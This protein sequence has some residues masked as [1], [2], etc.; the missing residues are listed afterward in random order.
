M[1][2]ENVIIKK[3][4][5]NFIR[6]SFWDGFFFSKICSTIII[7][8]D[9]MEINIICTQDDKDFKKYKNDIQKKKV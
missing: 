9:A 7:R 1:S 5:I 6:P 4:E 2:Q 8:I 3:N